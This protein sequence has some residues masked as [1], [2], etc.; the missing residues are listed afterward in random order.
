M[1][2]ALYSETMGN[3]R[4]LRYSTKI[5]ATLENIGWDGL[6]MC[7]GKPIAEPATQ[8]DCHM[9]D[10]QWHKENFKEDNWGNKKVLMWPNIEQNARR[11]RFSTTNQIWLVLLSS[12]ECNTGKVNKGWVKFTFT[13]T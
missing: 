10:I 3:V 13:H 8:S 9:L 12:S 7:N 2:Y 1:V 11:K 4:W 5:M 6:V